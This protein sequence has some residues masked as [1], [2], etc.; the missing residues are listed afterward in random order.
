M[1]TKLSTA[2]AFVSTFFAMGCCLGP[3]GLAT[4]A[5]VFSLEYFFKM[6]V[7]LPILYGLLGLT[8]IGH[9][10]GKQPTNKLSLLLVI[11][12]SAMVLYPL[13]TAL[14]V[15]LFRLLI[16]GGLGL[17]ILAALRKKRGCPQPQ[18]CRGSKF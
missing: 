3:P 6:Q 2:G 5:S 11:M 7:Q 12:G 18:S 14:D 16:Y 8:L 13:H 1:V 17:L 4:L 9:T 10:V 15:W